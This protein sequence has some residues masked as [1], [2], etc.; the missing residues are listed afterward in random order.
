MGEDCNDVTALVTTG[1]QSYHTDEPRRNDHGF[2]DILGGHIQILS[3]VSL[4]RRIHQ[5]SAAVLTSETM[6]NGACMQKK[7][8]YRTMHALQETS[9]LLSPRSAIWNGIRIE[10]HRQPAAECELCLPQHTF[11]ILL[12]ECHTERRVESERIHS[13]SAE[14]GEVILYPASSR[15]W[16]RWQEEVEFLLLFLDASLVAQTRES[17][18]GPNTIEIMANEKEFRDPL[19]Q[20]IGLALKAELDEGMVSSS[21]LYAESLATAVSAHILRRYT[22]QK[23]RDHEA[24][25]HSA[26]VVIQRVIEYIHENLG[27]QVTL[28][29][30]ALVANMSPYHFARTFKQA[31]GM[32]P[33]QYVLHTRIEH[34]RDLL[35]QGKLSIAQVAARVGFF[36]QSHFTRYFKRI[37]GVTPHTL[38]HQ[39][40]KNILHLP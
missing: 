18:G 36:D 19:L 35:L 26:H 5:E 2:C 20:Q 13:N 6:T 27:Q 9:P 12:G 34:A 7:T 23:S 14:Q 25:G 32:A 17:M 22:V 1:H 8:E 4:A 31:T 24:I 15:Q 30:L 11:C 21:A 40:S 29:E 16:I 28:A 38:L 33:H 39:N 10:H 3:I 37:V